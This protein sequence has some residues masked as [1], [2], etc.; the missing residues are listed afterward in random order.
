MALPLIYLF[1][2]GGGEDAGLLATGFCDLS[3]N[4]LEL[5]RCGAG[6]GGLSGGDLAMST[7]LAWA[8]AARKARLPSVVGN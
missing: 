6:L 5:D 7:S 2:F 3:I 1:G 4:T 8:E